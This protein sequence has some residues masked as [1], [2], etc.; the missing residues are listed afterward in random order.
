MLG[1]KPAK[2]YLLFSG[3]DAAGSVTGQLGATAAIT[4]G[5]SDRGA[6]F[7]GIFMSLFLLSAALAAPWTPRL[8]QRLRTPQAFALTQSLVVVGWISLGLTVALSAFNVAFMLV[9]APM[10][11]G[12]SGIGK[13]LKPLVT[14]DYLG[15]GVAKAYARRSVVTGV[16]AL[17][18]ALLAGVLITWT[19]PAVAIVLNGL[20]TL[21]LAVFSWL[22]PARTEISYAQA[23]ARPLR[24]ALLDVRRSRH[25]RQVVWFGVTTALFAAPVAVMVVPLMQE[26]RLAD[27]VSGAGAVVAAVGAGK[28][29]SPKIVAFLLRKGSDTQALRTCVL[30]SAGLLAIMGV[31]AALLS[32]PIQLAAWVLLAVGLGACLF[33]IRA[34]NLGAA[35]ATLGEGR[36]AE[37]LAAYQMTVGLAAPLGTLIFGLLLSVSSTP[38]TMGWAALGMAVMAATAA[39]AA[40]AR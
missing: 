8:S 24:S 11:G 30:L 4:F 20:L 35:S 5:H 16:F 22:R 21:P 18:G 25:L 36:A 19:I 38:Q 29:I 1:R 27:V 23:P 3:L 7:T 40:R 17:V 37:G 39:G 13:T 2:L 28:M 12:L 9:A 10:L 6:L 14:G 15:Q 33:T 26:F 34:L 31:T 32:G